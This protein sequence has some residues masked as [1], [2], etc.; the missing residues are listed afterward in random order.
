M[1]ALTLHL[2]SV[3]WNILYGISSAGRCQQWRKTYSGI[4][5][6]WDLR[7]HLNYFTSLGSTRWN[8]SFSSCIGK[9][10]HAQVFCV[11]LVTPNK[12]YQT[13][14][15]AD[16]PG[17]DMG[18]WGKMELLKTKSAFLG[19]MTSFQTALL[20]HGKIKELLSTIHSS[21]ASQYVYLKEQMVQEREKSKH[22]E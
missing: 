3:V 2:S 16:F 1:K 11:F 15:T 21:L 12:H 17:K 10:I 8:H 4:V 19:R 20:L 7:T 13:S 18:P 9:S 5:C 22:H 14:I 6:F